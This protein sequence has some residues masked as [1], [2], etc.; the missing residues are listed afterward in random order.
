MRYEQMESGLIALA[1]SIARK[2][3]R[4]PSSATTAR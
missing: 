2:R 4:R 1:L 3:V